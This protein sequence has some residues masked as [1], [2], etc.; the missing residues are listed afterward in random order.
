MSDSSGCKIVL[1]A[2]IVAIIMGGLGFASGFLTHAVL[3]ADADTPGSMTTVVVE[4]T[5]AAAEIE[6]P[7]TAPSV[8]GDRSP[9]AAPQPTAEPAPTI[10]IPAETGATFDL[11]W[12]AWDLI[13]RDYYG[14]LPSEE[15]MTYG[16]IRGALNTLDDPF[17]AFIEPRVAEINR[18]DDTGTFEGIGAYVTME[19]GRLM[20]VSTFKGQPAE[21]AGLRRNDIVLQVDDTPIENMSI[22]EAISL[23]RGE[24]GTPVELTI[25]REGEEPFEVEIIRAS[26]EIPVVESEM[27]EEGIAYV[28]LLD[29]SSDASAKMIDALDELLDQNPQGL[30]LDLRG[31]PGGWLN[32]AVLT[33]G[34]FLPKDEIVLLERFKDGTERPYT[35]PNEPVAP[36]VAMVVLVDGGSASASEIVAGALQ[37]HDRAVLVGE[38]TFGK[39]SVQWPHELSNGGELRVTVARWFTPADRAI[40]GEGLAPDIDV[41]MPLDPDAIEEGLDPQLD[42][43]VEYLL[44]GQ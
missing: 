4:V 18:E 22:Y 17:T 24:A 25:V 37:D 10:A 38:Q 6:P 31:N 34:L 2:V 5:S 9:T 20:I 27:L 8:A 44:T 14:D 33:A 21:E 7:A 15:A 39:G 1:T 12:E 11:F 42:R 43:A 16:A 23:I 3:V 32:E 19:D 29:F 35:A 40:H 41:E 13:Q 30:I 36:D 28:Q 26:I